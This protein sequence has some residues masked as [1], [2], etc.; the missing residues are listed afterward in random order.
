MHLFSPSDGPTGYDGCQE[1]KPAHASYE[2]RASKR[3]AVLLYESRCVKMPS[4]LRAGLEYRAR[5][6]LPVEEPGS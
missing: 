5:L 2:R 4:G 1:G 6:A 3:V